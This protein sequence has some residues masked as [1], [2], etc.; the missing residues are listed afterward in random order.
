MVPTFKVM[1]G[2]FGVEDRHSGG[3]EKV[4]ENVVELEAILGEGSCQTQEEL[5]ESLDV[6]PSDFHLTHLAQWHTAWLTST[7]PRMKKLKVGPTH[8]S[9]RKMKH[10]FTAGFAC[11]PRDGPKW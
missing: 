5:S 7:S 2:D 4:A 9:Y 11:C 8:G 1:G 6:V 3:R 10:F